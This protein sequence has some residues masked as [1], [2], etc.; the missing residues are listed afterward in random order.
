MAQRK[1]KS[2]SRKH[3]AS[4][5]NVHPK[6]SPLNLLQMPLQHKASIMQKQTPLLPLA[7]SPNYV[8][9]LRV[10]TAHLRESLPNDALHYFTHRKYGNHLGLSCTCPKCGLRPPQHVKSW[11]RWRWLAVHEISDHKRN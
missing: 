9:M 3:A 2:P 5:R 8:K 7:D 11:N 10:S 1:Q 4:T 6:P